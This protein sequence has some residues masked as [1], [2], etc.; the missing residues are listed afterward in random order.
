MPCIYA[1][2]PDKSEDTYHSF[3]EEVSNTLDLEHSLKGIIPDFEIAA[4]NTAAAIFEGREMKAYFF[5]LCSNLRKQ[6]QRSGLQQR[7]IDDV[8]F[9]NTL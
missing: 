5:H 4:I 1:L 2:L 9:T 7:C 8:E 6:I 3:F